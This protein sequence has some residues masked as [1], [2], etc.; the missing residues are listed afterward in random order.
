MGEN[1]ETQPLFWK[2]LFFRFFFSRNFR[3]ALENTFD[4]K[5]NDP[6]SEKYRVMVDFF[7]TPMVYRQT[8]EKRQE[9]T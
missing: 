7:G 9:N 8:K 3:Y 2:G 4:Q 6:S 1:M 5:K